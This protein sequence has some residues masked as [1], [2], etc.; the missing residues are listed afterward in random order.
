MHWEEM[1]ENQI[2]N[3]RSWAQGNTGRRRPQKNEWRL[4]SMNVNA[5]AGLYVPLQHVQFQVLLNH[6]ISLPKKQERLINRS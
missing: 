1:N 6:Q 5:R 3:L 2:E 4:V